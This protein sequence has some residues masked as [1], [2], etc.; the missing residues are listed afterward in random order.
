MWQKRPPCR[1]ERSQAQAH[2]KEH[3]T[4]CE[5]EHSK[6]QSETASSRIAIGYV[7][8]WDLLQNCLGLPWNYRGQNCLYNGELVF[9]VSTDHT[10]C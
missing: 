3:R 7:Q 1:L 10:L 6:R 5:E 4:S 9:R 2:R 8:Q